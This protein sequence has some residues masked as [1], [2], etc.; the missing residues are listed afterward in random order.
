[1]KVDRRL[2]RALVSVLLCA[3]IC[4]GVG[5]ADTGSRAFDEGMKPV[6]AAYLDI[7]KSLATDTVN[8]VA[9]GAARIST[10][11]ASLDGS[12]VSG[13]HAEEYRE[14]AAAVVSA[15]DELAKA[16]DL[17]AARE[18]FK[19]LSR[20][21]AAWAAVAAPPGISVVYCPMADAK[22]LQMAGAVR[23]PYFGSRMRACGKVLAGVSDRP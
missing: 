19:R 14:L 8:G 7:Q 9:D 2:C 1:M 17:D 15:A 12:A 21:M 20:P 13:E 22:W 6:V 4:A 10:T 3:G 5:W 18:A 16:S 23:K 11:A